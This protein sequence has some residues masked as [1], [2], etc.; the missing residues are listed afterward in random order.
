MCDVNV[1]EG[2]VCVRVEGA[3]TSSRGRLLLSV[4]MSAVKERGIKPRESAGQ[5]GQ[6]NKS[7]SHIAP[8]TTRCY[9][10]LLQ[11]GSSNR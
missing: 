9:L 4:Q 1:R 5:G 6:G 10:G 11:R 7:C 2:G 3:V 8:R